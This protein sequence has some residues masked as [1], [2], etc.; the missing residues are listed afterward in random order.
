MNHGGRV[1]VAEDFFCEAVW[2]GAYTVAAFDQT[3]LVF[4]SGGRPWR[5]KK[6]VRLRCASI[7]RKPAKTTAVSASPNNSICRCN[8]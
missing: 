4:G 1:E 3:D 2:A 6:A 8:A 7:V 5:D